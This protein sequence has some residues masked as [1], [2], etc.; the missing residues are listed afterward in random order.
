MKVKYQFEMIKN[1]S[2]SEGYTSIPIKNGIAEIDPDNADEM[3]LAQAMNG[4]PVTEKK[5]S[6]KTQVSK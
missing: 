1:G 5:S 6:K 3:K 4:K 2:I